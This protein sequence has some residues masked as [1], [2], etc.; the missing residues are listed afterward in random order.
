[1]SITFY[2]SPQSNATRIFT[3]L[4]ELGIPY[5]TVKVDLRAGDQRKP[6]FLALNPNGKVPTIVIDGTPMF[7]SVAI[8]IALGERYGVEKGLWPQLG[9]SE[10]LQALTWLVWGQVTLSGAMIS[11]MQ[12]T[13]DWIPK[14][15]H[16]A[17]AA[18]HALSEMKG[19]LAILDGRLNGRAH[20]TGDHFTLADLDLASVL[21][22][23]LHMCKID[24]SS[25]PHL[26]GWLGRVTQRPSFAA[27]RQ[28]AS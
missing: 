17:A 9:S 25:L 24:I 2:Y 12:N 3:S 7:E 15:R 11:Y 16:N 26:Q 5:E 4:V 1:M 27:E 10:H 23:G 19:L 13:S 20:V 6:E 28:S 8:Q 22:W 14:E 18:E 21:G